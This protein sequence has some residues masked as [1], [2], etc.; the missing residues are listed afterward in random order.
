MRALRS[1]DVAPDRLLVLQCRTPHGLTHDAEQTRLQHA[2]ATGR[3]RGKIIPVVEPHVLEA[4]CQGR[5]RE[6][7]E[8]PAN[9]VSVGVGDDEQ[10]KDPI[11]GDGTPVGGPLDLA[12]VA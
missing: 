5:I 11:I 4:R 6:Q 7:L 2:L 8:R 3:T 1:G 12:P 9:V 10:V